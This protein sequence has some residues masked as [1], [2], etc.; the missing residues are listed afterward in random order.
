M[1]TA[2]GKLHLFVAIDRITKFAF[3]QLHAKATRRVAG[4][5]PHAPW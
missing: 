2:E 1:R 3:V 4:D 5:L